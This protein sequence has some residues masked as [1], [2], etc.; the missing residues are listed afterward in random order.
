MAFAADTTAA[1]ATAYMT[2]HHKGEDKGSPFAG[3]NIT[4]RQRLLMREIMIE[5]R[6]NHGP[7]MK[8]DRQALHILVASD[9]FNVA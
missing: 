9:S 8:G 3:L 6:Q 5:S 7:G 2:M 4:E 1:P